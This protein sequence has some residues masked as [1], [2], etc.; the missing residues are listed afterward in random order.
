MTGLANCTIGYCTNIHSGNDLATIRGNLTQYSVAVRTSLG[1]SD[2]PVGLWIPSSA[3]LEVAK[4]VEGFKQFLSNHRLTP[5]TFNGFPFTDFHQ[6]VV[7]HAVYEPT[8]ADPQRLEYTIQLANILA[9]LL[10]DDGKPGTISTLPIGWPARNDSGT[11]G[12]DAGTSSSDARTIEKAGDQLRQ[13]ARSLAKLE[14]DTGRRILVAIEPEPGCLIDRADDAVRFFEQHLTDPVD[15]RYLTICH[16]VCHSS[17]MSESQT[18]VISAYANAGIAVGKLQVSSGIVGDWEMMATGR[19]REAVKQLADFAEDRY[20]HQTGRITHDDEF[21]LAEDLPVLL[22]KIPSSGD[23][24]WDDKRWVVHFHVPIFLERF[25][26]LTTT[27]SHIAEA[28]RAVTDPNIAVEFTGHIEIETYAWTV[29]PANM[30]RRSLAE[31]IAD[32]FRWLR[33]TIVEVM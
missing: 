29:L 11:S 12:G 4:D 10:P 18:K 13:L 30:R 5:Y 22:A 1:A 23:P 9:Q 33:K 19:R 17:V 24:V 6:K 28:L 7:K 25:G 2:L 15:R 31:D 27:Q 26:H 32:E 21:Y 20:L 16:D 14:G 8:W 3:A